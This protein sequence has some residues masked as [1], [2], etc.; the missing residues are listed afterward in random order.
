MIIFLKYDHLALQQ[1]LSQSHFI[2]RNNQPALSLKK[3]M[4]I[5]QVEIKQ[6]K[7]VNDEIKIDNRI[8]SW[9]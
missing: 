2:W 3:L 4:Q 7:K 9:K 6:V 5:P 1:V 8:I